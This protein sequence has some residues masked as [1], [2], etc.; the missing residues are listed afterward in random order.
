MLD[1][2][3]TRVFARASTGLQ[4]D[5][6]A[7]SVGSR[8]DG[9]HLLQVVDVESGDAVTKHGRMVQEFAH[10]DECHGEILKNKKL[11]SGLAI[12]KRPLGSQLTGR[13]A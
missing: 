2:V 5:G 1:E 12:L 13:R 3:L 9:L 11:I 10:R 4:D 6:R 7:H 8:H